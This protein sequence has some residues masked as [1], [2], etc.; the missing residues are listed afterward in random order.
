MAQTPAK[1]LPE[2]LA[3][4][5]WLSFLLVAA[6]GYFTDAGRRPEMAGTTSVIVTIVFAVLL[7]IGLAC[8][9]IALLS[10]RKHGRKGIL[11][12]ALLGSILTAGLLC[13]MTV[14]FVETYHTTS[15]RARI[16]QFVASMQR[17]LPHRDGSDTEL[18]RVQAAG[19]ELIFDYTFIHHKAAQ[20]DVP[21]LEKLV[22]PQI[23]ATFCEEIK[24]ALK[25]PVDFRVR[26]TSADAV[27]IAQVIVKES[28]C[29]R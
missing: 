6:V 7:L 1:P 11:A 16:N 14:T 22:R 19:G 26:Y 4:A 12:P 3:T 8:G 27:Q 25:A 10:V 29:G 23:K 17:D 5:S 24:P 21:V 15:S 2:Q 18:T 28:E 9:I 20:I 13:L